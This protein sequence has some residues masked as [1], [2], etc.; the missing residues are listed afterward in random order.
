MSVQALTPMTPVQFMLLAPPD[1][2]Q[3]LTGLI[4]GMRHAG[5]YYAGF[6][7]PCLES[8]PSRVDINVLAALVQSMSLVTQE[9]DSGPVTSPATN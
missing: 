2:T 6:V 8:E 4:D 3:Y 9:D 7:S 5:Y 1:Q